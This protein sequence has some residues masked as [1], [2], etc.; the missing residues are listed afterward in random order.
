MSL[1]E[2]VDPECGG[3]NP[4]MRLG[5]HMIHDAAHKDDGIAGTAPPHIAGT[6][7]PA[8]FASQPLDETHL[9]NEFLGQ[10]AAPPPQ[11]FRMDAL[12]QEMREIDARNYP[13]Q[14]MRAPPVSDE[15]NK[16]LTWA[17]E[18]HQES[19]SSTQED[20]NIITV[21]ERVIEI[22]VQRIRMVISNEISFSDLAKRTTKIS[23]TTTIA[24]GTDR[25]SFDTRFLRC[26]ND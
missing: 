23:R 19:G 4:L 22:W 21:G 20:P 3:A 15:I 8:H 16:G 7:G 24:I 13:T 17:N 14:V 9:V 12:L 11:S 10:M 26:T 1:R 6:S 2:L 5:S 18:Y 25:H